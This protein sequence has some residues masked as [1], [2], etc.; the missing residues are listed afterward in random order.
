MRV[1]I[2]ALEAWCPPTLTPEVLGRT[3]LA[4][5]TTA[6]ANHSTRCS[7][8]LITGSLGGGWPISRTSIAQI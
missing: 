7:T 6:V 3:R 2:D 1:T 4:W 8:A 5:S